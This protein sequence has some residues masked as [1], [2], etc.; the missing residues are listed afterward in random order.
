MTEI[1]KPD[2]DFAQ[3]LD[4]NCLN[5]QKGSTDNQPQLRVLT[6]R[7]KA[8]PQE[9]EVTEHL[10]EKCYNCFGKGKPPA[11]AITDTHSCLYRVGLH[12]K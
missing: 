1:I 12:K 11:E 6:G 2:P 4:L 5:C 7:G 3:H 8:F 9:K 10:V